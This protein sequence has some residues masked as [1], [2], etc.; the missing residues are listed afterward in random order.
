MDGLPHI[1]QSSSNEVINLDPGLLLPDFVDDGPAV[2]RGECTSGNELLNGSGSLVLTHWHQ[3]EILL[4]N[5][6]VIPAPS[7]GR[8]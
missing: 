6:L 3:C 7:G 2:H 5:L 8:G 1:R 4:L